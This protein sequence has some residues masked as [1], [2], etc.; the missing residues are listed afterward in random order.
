[1]ALV[2]TM[3]GWFSKTPQLHTNTKELLVKIMPFIAL[4]FG[5][6]GMLGG[7]AGLGILTMFAPLAVFGG[8]QGVASY[9][10]GFLIALLLLVS[11]GLLLAAFPGTKARKVTGWILLFYSEI[12]SLVSAILSMNILSGILVALIAFYLL[13]QIRS[14]YK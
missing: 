5:V 4:I 13:F 11:S 6:L 7:L 1:M 10:G 8:A 3:D 9:G 2:T 14:Y 12:V